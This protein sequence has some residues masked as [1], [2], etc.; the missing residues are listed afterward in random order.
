MGNPYAAC[1]SARLG[2]RPFLLYRWVPGHFS[3]AYRN[4]KWRDYAARC[5]VRDEDRGSSSG[6]LRLPQAGAG[7]AGSN[8]TVAAPL[9]IEDGEED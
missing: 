6:P 8:G 3:G 7:G 1:L 5:S 9:L 4:Y 2:Y